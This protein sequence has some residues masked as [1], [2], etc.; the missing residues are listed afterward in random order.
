MSLDIRIATAD[1]REILQQLIVHIESED[2]PD[3]PDAASHAPAGMRRSLLHYDALGAD[4]VWFLIAEIDHRPAGLAILIRIPKLDHR[5]GFLYLDELYVVRA[6][7]RQGIGRALLERALELCAALSLA[8][9]RLLA[10]PDN[11]PART[12]YESLGFRSNETMLY[13]RA[14]E[15]GND[16]T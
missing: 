10:R 3:D 11:L 9:I 8:G 14:I 5:V 2:H 1:D 12:L 15:S 7:R 16:A 6:L 4:S 13:Q